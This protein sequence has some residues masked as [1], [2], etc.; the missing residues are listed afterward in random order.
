MRTPILDHAVAR[1]QAIDLALNTVGGLI[2]AAIPV[3][4][5]FFLVRRRGSLQ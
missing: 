3:V 1:E 2:G 4:V 5:I